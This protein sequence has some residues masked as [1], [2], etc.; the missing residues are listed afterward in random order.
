[1]PQATIPAWV[2]LPSGF[3][4]IRGEPPS[5]FTVV[6]ERVLRRESHR[7]HIN[8]LLTSGTDEGLAVE[9][10]EPSQFGL[11]QQTLTLAVVHNLHPDLLQDHLQ[12]GLVPC[13][14]SVTG[15]PWQWCETESLLAPAS[16]GTGVVSEGLAGGGEADGVEVRGEGEGAGDLHQG[17]VVLQIPGSS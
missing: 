2:K 13:K 1:M 6:R 8:V 10:E 9:S 5:P 7:A 14:G 12:L 15:R 17:D 11:P 4:H 16:G 3:R